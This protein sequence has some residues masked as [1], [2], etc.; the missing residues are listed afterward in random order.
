[1]KNYMNIIAKKFVKTL[2]DYN[3]I[4]LTNSI[5]LKPK[6]RIILEPKLELSDYCE[7]MTY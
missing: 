6:I 5:I 2:D 4:N 1:M 7:N 3:L